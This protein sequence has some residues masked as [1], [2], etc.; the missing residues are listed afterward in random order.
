MNHDVNDAMGGYHSGSRSPHFTSNNDSKLD[1]ESASP[2]IIS[3]LKSLF[4]QSPGIHGIDRSE[5][6]S[7]H[8]ISNS[9]RT[10]SR[11]SSGLS[12][13]DL[14][15]NHANFDSCT[16][17]RSHELNPSFLDMTGAPNGATVNRFSDVKRLLANLTIPIRHTRVNSGGSSVQSSSV[18]SPRSAFFPEQSP[19]STFTPP[20]TPDSPNGFVSSTAF[21]EYEEHDRYQYRFQRQE[22]SQ[23]FRRD[24]EIQNETQPYSGIRIREEDNT[25]RGGPFSHLEDVKEGKRPAHPIVCLILLISCLI[26]SN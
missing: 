22:H 14:Y 3:R 12:I 7:V 11:V 13:N 5:N 6:I 2:T 17:T 19:T 23:D 4:S 10:S 21:S 8:P 20:L 9:R 16:H 15:C 24:I 26:K 25:S 18:Y 1:T